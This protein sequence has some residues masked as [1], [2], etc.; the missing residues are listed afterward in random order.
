MHVKN[1]KSNHEGDSM[2]QNKDID[3]SNKTCNKIIG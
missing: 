2:N 3:E 1:E